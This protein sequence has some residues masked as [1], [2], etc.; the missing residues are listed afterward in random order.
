MSPG[1]FTTYKKESFVLWT[2]TT[3]I[4][5]FEFGMHQDCRAEGIKRF[6]A[7]ILVFRPEKYLYQSTLIYWR[8]FLLVSE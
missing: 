3:T 8:K 2:Q 1:L 5:I 7:R 6:N 4:D